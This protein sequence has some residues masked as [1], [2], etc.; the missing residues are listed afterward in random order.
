MHSGV[1]MNNEEAQVSNIAIE[2]RGP[3][4]L[5]RLSR[6]VTNALNLA[7]VNELAALLQQVGSDPG[8]RGL[9]LASA[10]D[11]FFSLGFDIPHL[12]GQGRDD[13]N[14]FFRAFNRACLALYTLPKPTVAAITGHAI[15]GGCILALCCDY[16]FIAQ[17]RKLMGLNEV[18]LGVPVPHLADCA[19]RSLVGTGH[20]RQ[21][22]ESG[23]FY[24]PEAAL[25]MGMVDRVLPLE[26]VIDR[27]VD[28]AGELDD[29]PAAA[30]GAIKRNRVE[31]IEAEV[32]AR[33]EERTRLFIEC[34]YSDEAR[35]RLQEAMQKF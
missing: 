16:R 33:W 4:A 35:Q 29:L 8:V 20:A 28:K 22:M 25:E 3:V 21:I 15:A 5:L 26:E 18:R 6:D 31:A 1:N 2:Q 32:L 13:M 14:R 23:E 17:G 7:S 12:Y 27:A 10:N 19:L 9:V 24:A 30:F 11:K 34:W